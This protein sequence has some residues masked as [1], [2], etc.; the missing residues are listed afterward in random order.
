MT[1]DEYLLQLIIEAAAVRILLILH[2]WVHEMF[3]L[4]QIRLWRTG[5]VCLCTP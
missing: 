3:G 4:L 5:P 1:L 2:E